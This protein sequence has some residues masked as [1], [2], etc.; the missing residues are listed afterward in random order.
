MNT[1]IIRQKLHQL[2]DT[3]DDKHAEAMYIL[4]SSEIDTDEQR[5]SLIRA[6]REKYLSNTG[7]SFSPEEVKKMA[8]DKKLRHGL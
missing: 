2:I 8:L 5:K 6:E 7:K 1:M 4:L 3:L